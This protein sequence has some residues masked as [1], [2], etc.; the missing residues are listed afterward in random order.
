MFGSEVL[1]VA[2]GLVFIYLLLSLICS[3]INEWIARIC[4]LRSKTLEEGIR[5]LLSDPDLAKKFY[6]HPLIK[7]LARQGKGKPSYIP[8]RTFALVLMDVVTPADPSA[9]PR[10]FQDVR[11]AVAK[12]P[13]EEARKALLALINETGDDLKKVRENIEGWFDDAMDR[14]SGWYKRK[15]QWIILLL[16]LGVTVGLNANTIT[17]SKALW[18]NSTVRA[19]V[20]SAAQQKVVK[21]S[22]SADSGSLKQIEAEIR[23]LQ[24]FQLPIGWSGE[25]LPW[26]ERIVGWLLTTIAVS[27]GAPFWFDVLNK[28]VN[29]RSAGKQPEKKPKKQLGEI[30]G[31]SAVAV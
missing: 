2:I 17:I 24:Q 14:V 27:L 7:G 18:G 10:V 3:A 16:A 23:E 22:V 6:Q 4:A 26:S 29:L 28:L 19:S 15:M 13:Y 5:N 1:D 8:S 20:V 11:D 30:Q 9:G 31:E 25:H 21:P 12:L